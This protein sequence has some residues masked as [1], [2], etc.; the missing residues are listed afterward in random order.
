MDR[1][2]ISS[3]WRLIEPV[4]EPDGIE[5][6]EIEFKLEGGRW[7]LRLYIDSPRGRDAG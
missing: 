4:L 1:E 3:L 6:V 7:V 2:L 5:L